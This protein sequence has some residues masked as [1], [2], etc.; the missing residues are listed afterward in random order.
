ME[1][2]SFIIIVFFSC[3]TIFSQKEN[4]SKIV[5]NNELLDFLSKKKNVNFLNKSGFY[6]LNIPKEK[7]FS[8]RIAGTILISDTSKFDITKINV[9]FLMN[10]YQYYLV[11]NW[12]ILLV[13]KSIDHLKNEMKLVE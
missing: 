5:E 11:S 3:I 2:F 6:F 7:P 1:R 12:N 8:N 10:D 4:P 9:N 13:L